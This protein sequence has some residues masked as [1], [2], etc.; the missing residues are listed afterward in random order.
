[1]LPTPPRSVA[2]HVR[3]VALGA[4]AGGLEPLEQFLAQV[5]IRSGL[6][7]LVVQHMDPTHKAMLS[8]LLQRTTE[9]PVREATESQPIEPDAVYVIPPNAELT[10]KNGAIHL[11]V[12]SQPR[13]RRMPIDVLFSSLAREL[14]DRAIG[15]VLSGMG[16]D[17]TLGLRAIKSQGGLTVAQAPESAQ[18]DSMPKS[19]IAAGCVDIVTQ[20]STMPQ[21]ILSVT[22]ERP[23]SMPGA[24][25]VDDLDAAPLAAILNLLHAHSKHDLRQYKTSTLLRRIDRRMAVHELA[26]MVAY[27]AFLRENPQELDLLFKEMLIGVTSFFRDGSVWQD[28]KDSMLPPLLTRHRGV[29]GSLRAWVVGC[30]TGEEAY[31]LAMLYT[32]AVEHLPVSQRLPLQIFATDL[33]ADAI[34]VARAGLYPASIARDVEPERLGRFF[35]HKSSGYLINQGI[36]DMVRFA[37]H[38]VILD[39]PFTRLDILCC[40]NLMIYFDAALQQRLIPLFH[41]SLRP[42]GVLLLGGSETVGRAQ[43]MFKPLHPKTRLYW[44]IDNGPATKMAVFPTPRRPTARSATLETPVAHLNTASANLQSLADQALLQ[45]FSPPAVL[46]NDSGDVL[47][48]NGRTGVYLEPAAGKANWN[49]HVMARPGIRAQLAVALRTALKDKKPV[50]LRGLRLDDETPKII[51][52]TVQPILQPAGIAGMALIVF[53]DVVAPIRGRRHK[54]SGVV[55]TAVGD[56]L[57]RSREEVRALRQDM[58]ASQEE[59]Q[60]AN[61]ELQSINEELQS[62]NEELTTSK[63]EAQSMNEELQTVNGELQSKLDDLALAQSDM[64][65]LLN[66]IDIATLFLDN[67]L[68]VRR[69]T[70]QIASVFHL[71]EAD[72]GRPLSELATTLIYPELHTDVKET[73]RTLMF[74]EKEITTA[75]GH[76]FSVRIMPYR[77][78][79]NVIQ[80]A[81]ITFVDI[82]SAKELESRLRNV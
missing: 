50:E 5:P 80:G 18:F 32:E 36:R 23:R 20:P 77:T 38:D 31:T 48:L 57:I 66:S 40:R 42:G 82:T 1:M 30:S 74:S 4:S 61:E 34:A 39:P 45:A 67:G 22:F 51:D 28:L 64:Q 47:Y 44:R 29:A 24:D 69:F 11:A 19:A 56:D 70:E 15:V 16:S 25:G 21:S 17:G 55:D 52:I 8:D 49:I 43:A 2:Q 63:E 27:V 41:Y 62:A 78:Q 14:G 73:L 72:I 12:P 35:H 71:R 7:Y 6:A 75:D 81:V 76:W 53:R 59:L 58:Q 46:V 13:G 54:A 79:A 10:V 26:T 37:Q 33:S 65:N 68:N 9:M 60:A 3:I